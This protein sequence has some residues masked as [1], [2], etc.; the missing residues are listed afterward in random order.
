MAVGW[1]K[2]V[3][4]WVK[5]AVRWVKMAVGGQDGGRV[6]QDG[7]RVGQDGGGVGQ[8]GGSAAN[9]ATPPRTAILEPLTPLP[10]LA[11]SRVTLRCRLGPAHPPAAVQ[12][13]R[14]D[15]WEVPPPAPPSASTPTPPAPASI[16]ALAKIPPASPSPR[17]FCRR[18][19]CGGFK[20][21]PPPNQWRRFRGGGPPKFVQ[22]LQSPGGPV[23]AG[24]GPVRLHCRVGAAEP[25]K[26]KVTW[27]KNGRELP[28]PAPTLLL[29]GPEPADAAAYV[30]QARNEV[31]GTRSPPPQPRRPL[32]P[33]GGAA[34]A[35][36]ESPCPRIDQ[37]HPPVSR[38]L[39]TPTQTF[40]WFREGRPLGRSP[41]GL[42]VM[43]V[44]TPQASGRYRCRVTNDIAAVDSSDV[45]LTVY[46]STT[47]ILQRTFL[48]LGVGLTIVLRWAP[49]GAS[50]AAGGSGRWR[51]M[52]NLW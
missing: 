1:V 31:G 17:P 19:V 7:G 18:L 27:F 42:W 46:H 23:V 13:R 43:G 29:P 8:D 4:D 35:G 9:T 30:C 22:V 5:M 51:P 24:G 21:P 50:S 47:T 37:R 10:A 33:P 20:F 39:P 28:D 14:D 52:K 2:M 32:P 11:G 45:I 12:W 25:P 48:G 16:A 3:I 49:L 36:P 26:V 44:V 6:G 38:H 40:E 15:R 34:G 41:K